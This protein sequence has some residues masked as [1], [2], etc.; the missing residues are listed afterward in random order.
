MTL[1]LDAQVRDPDLLQRIAEA[2]S[3][4]R[5]TV[6]SSCEREQQRRD[7]LAS[8]PHGQR[9]RVLTHQLLH[10]KDG[11]QR[12]D[13]RH[14]HSVL[15]ICALPYTR[16][17]ITTR[18]W[19]R[20]QGQMKLMVQAGT[21]AGKNGKWEDQPLPYGSRARLMLLHTC[22]EALRQK[23]PVIEI[24]DSLTG[25]IRAMG[26]AATG[27]K[28][29]TITSF[30]QQINAL[31]SCTMRIG[32]WDAHGSKTVTT[33]PFTSLEVFFSKDSNQRTL[34]PSTLTF[35]QDF[36]QT[37]TKHALPINMH[38]V[39]AFS[40]SPRKLDILFWLGYRLNSLERPM[41]IS[42]DS[43]RDQFGAGYGRSD[44]FRRDFAQEIHQIM[45]VF[46]KLPAKVSEVGFTLAPGSSEALAIPVKSPKGRKL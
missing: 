13:L 31:A 25:F 20:E 1:S 33:Q 16:Q 7:R 3:F 19:E 41:T 9:R 21:L 12:Q 2:P 23:S 26:F 40:S 4:V 17:P 14:I 36:Y 11:V 38:A 10:E 27:G 8:L 46:P 29:G 43:L 42:W 32:L 5:S 34:W 6:A 30:K 18:T 15:A 28:N 35:S 24:E 45:E 22:S 37:L 39:K 44:N